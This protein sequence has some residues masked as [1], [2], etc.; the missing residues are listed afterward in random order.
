MLAVLDGVKGSWLLPVVL[1]CPMELE[2]GVAVRQERLSL[3]TK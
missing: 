1:D 2:D 3:P